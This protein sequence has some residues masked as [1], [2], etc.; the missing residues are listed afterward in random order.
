MLSSFNNDPARIQKRLE[1]SVYPG[2]RQL[3]TP[4]PGEY[5]PF[6][7][8]P[9]IRLQ[10]WGANL[11]ADTVNLE[12][13]LKGM[14][15]NTFR[16]DVMEYNQHRVPQQKVEYP[17]ASPFVL[18]SRASQPAWQFRELDIANRHWDY[19][20]LNPQSV[21]VFYP[22]QRYIQTRILVKDAEQLRD[23][24]FVPA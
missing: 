16:G 5:L 6:L 20:I 14:T 24:G 7:E 22:F 13:D 1:E 4:G 17:V 3:N 8:D 9:N 18:E 19:P 12:S 11:M 23:Y 10:Q 2:L 21:G 15:R